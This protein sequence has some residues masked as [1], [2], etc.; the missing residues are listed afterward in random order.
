MQT[1][2]F[3]FFFYFLIPG[4]SLDFEQ[5]WETGVFLGISLKRSR[6]T[7]L[8]SGRFGSPSCS[9]SVSWSWARRRS[10][11]GAT[12]RAT[13]CATPSS[14]VAPTSATTAPSLLP[15]SA[16]GCCR[17]CL[18]PRPHSSTWATP[19]TRCVWRRRG[20]GWSRR[21]GRLEGTMEKTCRR[22][23]SS[24]SR[25]RIQLRGQVVSV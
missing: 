4:V 15:T 5:R 24:S 14:P 6:S 17:S 20:R 7:P 23:R 25:N 16:T 10:R 8:R 12:S 13:S 1:L 18:S 11:P 3:F 21:R 22:R 9:F 2:F 19:C